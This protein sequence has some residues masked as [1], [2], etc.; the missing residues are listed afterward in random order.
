[1]LDN[2]LILC[3]FMGMIATVISLLSPLFFLY[4]R[5]IKVIQQERE[6]EH[7]IAKKQQALAIYEELK[8]QGR[9]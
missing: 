7:T 4:I 5:K 1:M 3:M 9:V 8:A 2:M 6:M